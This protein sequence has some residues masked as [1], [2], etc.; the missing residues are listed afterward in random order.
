[1]SDPNV[2]WLVVSN[3]EAK[4]V[5]RYLYSSAKLVDSF[6]TEIPEHPAHLVVVTAR[7]NVEYTTNYQSG[8]LQ[9]GLMGVRIF[10]TYIKALD[11]ILDS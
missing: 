4:T 2:R 6:D 8:R 1:M 10:D 5:E 9:S 3:A 11:A 7:T